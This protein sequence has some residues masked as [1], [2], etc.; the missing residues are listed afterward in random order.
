[1]KHEIFL[2]LVGQAPNAPRGFDLAEIR[3]QI[4][5]LPQM[6]RCKNL[7][8]MKLYHFG[9]LTVEKPLSD[10]KVIG[11]PMATVTLSFSYKIRRMLLTSACH[12][13]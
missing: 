12:F 6:G 1:L 10:S 8:P 2:N 13:K 11:K 4:D 3:L 7:L 9:E 5:H